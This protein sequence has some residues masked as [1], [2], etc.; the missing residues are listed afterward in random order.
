MQERIKNQ[1]KVNEV[2]YEKQTLD[3][4]YQLAEDPALS[5][6]TGPD[7]EDVGEAMAVGAGRRTRPKLGL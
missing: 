2:D 3:M 6:K 4:L 1:L 7:S 5:T